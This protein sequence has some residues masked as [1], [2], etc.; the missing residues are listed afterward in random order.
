MPEKK[1]NYL[2]A[3]QLIESY[4]S[5]I[6]REVKKIVSTKSKMYWLHLSRRIL[7]S[8]SGKDKSPITIGV[9][10]KIIDGAIEKFGKNTGGINALSETPDP[11]WNDQQIWDNINE[12]WLRDAA[13]RNDV[14]RVVSDPNNPIN[15]INDKGQISFFAR[16]HNLLTTPVSQGGLGY[17]YNPLT[18]TYTK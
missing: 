1:Y 13:N 3:K 5:S 2:E 18:Y 12:P 10:R 6:L 15:L 7:T 9:T 14:I 8:T 17:T 4:Y 11:N 16:E